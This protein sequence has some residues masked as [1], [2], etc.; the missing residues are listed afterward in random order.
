MLSKQTCSGVCFVLF[1]FIFFISS[2]EHLPNLPF[3]LFYSTVR[4]KEGDYEGQRREW[5]IFEILMLLARLFFPDWWQRT[6]TQHD[7][8]HS[9]NAATDRP[10]CNT[11]STISFLF[12][13]ANSHQTCISFPNYHSPILE[14][15]TPSMITR[16]VFV[17][18]HW[19]HMSVI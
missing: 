12:S 1:L 18:K 2:C 13:T 17:H 16:D 11:S 7:S 19:C 6:T 10:R 4:Q 5:G 9:A 8:G 14:E 15:N 3:L